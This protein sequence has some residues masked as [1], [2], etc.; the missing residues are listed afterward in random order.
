MEITI[1]RL[2]HLG[3]GLAA[4]P[5]FVD[6]ALPGEVVSGDLVGDRLE[7]V[8]IIESSEHR[9]ASSCSAFKRCGGCS[10]HHISPD[11]VADWKRA[12]VVRA[13]AAQGIEIEVQVIHTSPENSRRRA[14]LSS[15]RTKKGATVGF[16]G[17]ASDIIQ[18]I[19]PCKVLAPEIMAIIP[20]LEQF[21]VRFGSRKGQLGFW[22]L[23]TD[24]GIDVSVEGMDHQVEND[25]GPFARWA[26]L[27][28]I[29]RLSVGGETIC[30]HQAPH[31]T[32]GKVRVITP[33]CA[34]TQATP[35]GEGAL[36]EAVGRAL[37]GADR[38]VDLFS[39]AG[40]LGLPLAE[41][42]TL[43][44]LENNEGLLE[45]LAHGVRHTQGIKKVTTSV[46]DLY[47]NPIDHTDLTQFNAAIIDPPRSGAEQQVRQLAQSNLCDIA[48]VSCNPVTFAR[49]AN[50]LCAGGY[51]LKWV[52][53]VD[54]FRWSPHIEIVAHFN[55]S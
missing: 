49:D 53:V 50:L 24:T 18:T 11:F 26:G 30:Q 2:G 55:K 43:H 5:I 1:E 14:K 23:S 10:L 3:D 19:E 42:A 45:A 17:K 4:G 31:L 20:A 25:L 22:V 28:G 29:A 54:Q 39:G 40:T 38:V 47:R 6:R 21:A 36:Q 12:V 44:C 27:N 32:F 35:Q 8:R 34:F 41:V 9:I 46:R 15:R 37:D 33:P 51:T 16:F 13:L 48:M 52:E 7:N